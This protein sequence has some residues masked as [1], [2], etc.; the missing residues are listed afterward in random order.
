MWPCGSHGTART[1]DPTTGALRATL[2]GHHGP[3]YA[4]AFSPDGALLA[5]AS[6]DGTTRIWNAYKLGS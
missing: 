6:S 5:T 4:V 3:V 1:W 2:S